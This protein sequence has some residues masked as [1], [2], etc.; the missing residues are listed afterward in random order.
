[1]DDVKTFLSFLAV[2]KNISASSQNQAFNALLFLFRHVLEREFG[3]VEGVVRAK[4]RRTI[5][6]VL[7]REEV[8]RIVARLDARY[9]LVAKL[10][11]GCGLRLFECLKLRVQDLNFA[12]R[13]LTVHDGKGQKDRTV[14]LLETLVSELQTQLRNCWGTATC[15]RP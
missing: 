13:V 10:L 9:V 11:F 3:K 6:V 5:P 7:S 2:H 15:A 14:P 12:M 8:D 4:R 1:M